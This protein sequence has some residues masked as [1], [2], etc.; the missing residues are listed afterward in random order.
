MADRNQEWPVLW[1]IV[2]LNWSPWLSKGHLNSAD[3]LVLTFKQAIPSK[4]YA[5]L[6]RDTACPVTN[7]SGCA[8]RPAVVCHSLSVLTRAVVDFIQPVVG[9]VLIDIV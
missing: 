2:A 4:V 8:T 3:M 5:I 1:Y 6:R 9:R 7:L